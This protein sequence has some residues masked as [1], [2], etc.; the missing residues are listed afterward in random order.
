MFKKELKGF[1]N[2]PEIIYKFK[3]RESYLLKDDKAVYSY[4][5]ITSI[6]KVI[7]NLDPKTV[8]FQPALSEYDAHSLYDEDTFYLTDL[9]FEV[10]G[11]L[12]EK[13]TPLGVEKVDFT[14][15]VFAFDI[16]DRTLTYFYPYQN[17]T[18]RSDLNL[19]MRN[20]QYFCNFKDV[21]KEYK[22]GMSIAKVKNINKLKYLRDYNLYC[23]E[24]DFY[25]IDYYRN[26]FTPIALNESVKEILKSKKYENNF[27]KYYW[28][29]F[30]LWNN[31]IVYL[32]QSYNA[33][34]FLEPNKISNLRIKKELP[35]TSELKDLKICFAT[36]D[37]LWL[38][39]KLIKNICDFDTMEFVGTIF[40][41]DYLGH[42]YY[43]KDK[44]GVY[45]Y[46]T[47][48]KKMKKL[49][50]NPKTFTEM[51]MAELKLKS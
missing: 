34:K 16:N 19:A 12:T 1:P 15:G 6:L 36:K 7:S 2:H 39:N 3:D 22:N 18:F 37:Y 10:I 51:K 41:N 43:F 13:N 46:H 47:K 27:N 11:D 28:D 8:H 44:N 49:S 48:G 31:K 38:E 30:V 35:L 23:Y 29:S 40:I 25:I 14:K 9:D 4:N 20:N 45:L 32:N 33:I 5:E 42:D 50:Y 21:Y 17:I 24:N 26:E